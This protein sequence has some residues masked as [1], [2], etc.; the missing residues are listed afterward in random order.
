VQPVSASAQWQ[1]PLARTVTLHLGDVALRDALARLESASHIRISYSAEALPLERRVCLEYERVAI[2][3]A[4]ARMLAGTNVHAVVAGADH[5]VLAPRAAT[6][7]QDDAEIPVVRHEPVIAATTI[8]HT[9]RNAPSSTTVI[10]GA[11]LQRSGA[12]TLAQAMNGTVPGLWLWG[13]SASGLLAQYGSVRGASSFGGNAPKVYIDGIE[14]ANP[15]LLNRLP[16]DA[17]D[18]IEVIRGPQG[19]ALYGANAI[20]GVTNII[21]RH[22]GAAGGAARLSVQSGFGVSSSDFATG[23]AFAQDHAA[24]LRAGSFDRSLGV[25]V[26]LGSL[27]E[28]A[29][30]ASARHISGDASGRL[31]GNRSTLTA[32]LRFL[33]ERADAGVNPLVSD[34]LIAALRVPGYFST[35]LDGPRSVRQVT[36]G[37]TAAFQPGSHWTHTV[38]AGVDG[39][40]LDYDDAQNAFSPRQP[41]PRGGGSTVGFSSTADAAEPIEIAD[42]TSAWRGTLRLSSARAVEIGD[43][44]TGR[45]TLSAEH[46]VLQQREGALE[47]GRANTG[48]SAQTE[49][50]I[51][52]RL[53]ISGGVRFEHDG[54]ITSAMRAAVLPMLG[55]SY[56]IDNGGM[57]VKLRAAYGKAIRWPE[58]PAALRARDPVRAAF[59]SV[60]LGPE[61]QSGIEGG[62]DVSV[63]RTLALQLTHFDQTALSLAPAET[64]AQDGGSKHDAYGRFS[65]QSVGRIANRG[66]EMLAS[67]TH[68]RVSL[69]GTASLVNSRVSALSAGYS[70][71]LRAG[72]RMLGVP[73]RTLS[74]TASW[75]AAATRASFTVARAADWIN[76]DLLALA[77]ADSQNHTGMQL[78]DYW[79]DYDGVT[80]L[81]A[82]LARELGRG[83]SLTLT[84]ENLLDRQL[85]EPD[86]ITIGPGRTFSLGIRAAF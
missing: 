47:Q 50:A 39:Y 15:L 32:T 74:L 43:V 35:T 1:A 80:H 2:G 30:D 78:R 83:L 40:A 11:E 76:Y 49:F 72:D 67:V 77:A 55:G 27:G 61:Q 58:L 71:E 41:A 13:Q 26:S 4:L 19:A 53:F 51:D 14:L 63:G 86:N 48:L 85:G 46:S 21:T 84:G 34:S 59:R 82:A 18:R 38:V 7:T 28:F 12:R 9:D 20:G 31:V 81:R 33:A 29:P 66:W 22:D 23:S 17:I 5:V 25:N 45:I 64:D 52:D 44:A 10:T 24:S 75:N 16:V 60:A 8:R 65:P 79:R 3:E 6:R 69:A 62:V 73:A 37:L 42:I 70:G 57:S 68:G 56:V 54:G 36:G